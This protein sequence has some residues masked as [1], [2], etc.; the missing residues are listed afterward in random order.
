MAY[1]TI[2]DY[3]IT[4][5]DDILRYANTIFPFAPIFLLCVFLI[6]SL[7]TFFG[8]MRG[9][10][11][12]P[13]IFGSMMVGGFITSMVAFIMTLGEGIISTYYVIVC[14]VLTLLFAASYFFSS[15]G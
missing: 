3:N 6:V 1:Q 15:R 12:A 9:S 4:G 2:M 11:G 10:R 13:D 8:A 14:I 7:A 5:V